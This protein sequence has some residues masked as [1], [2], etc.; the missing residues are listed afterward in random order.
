MDKSTELLLSKLDDK[1]N[2]Q[3]KIIT[4]SVTK[5][6]MEALDEKLKAITEENTQLKARI[7]TLEQKINVMDKEKRKYNL[8][9]FGLKELGKPEAELVDYIKDIVIETGIHLDSQEISNV[10]R[11]GKKDTNKNR[12]VIVSVTSM[13]KKH[14]ILRNKNR[15]PP[16]IF[17][18]EDFPKEI[19]EKRK[20]LQT[21][22]IEEKKKGNVAYL[23]YDEEANRQI[24]RQK[25][26]GG[27]RLT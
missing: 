11:I 17:I 24:Q 3:T 26:K 25:K 18:K 6:V 23:K 19:L 7:S 13:W 4:A 16:G 21:Q 20:Q 1:L 15:F 5:C 9:F 8:V 10:Y 14:I 27:V 12:P 2:Q 22:V